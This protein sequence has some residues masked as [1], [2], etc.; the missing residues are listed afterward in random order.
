MA[1]QHIRICLFFIELTAAVGISSLTLVLLNVMQC[2]SWSVKLSST[3]VLLWIVKAVANF[4]FSESQD[5]VRKGTDDAANYKHHDVLKN[6][7]S[8][9]QQRDIPLG[10]HDGPKVPYKQ[11]AMMEETK[12]FLDEESE[13]QDHAT[14]SFPFFS[15]LVTVFFQLAIRLIVIF[16]NITLTFQRRRRQAAVG[17]GSKSVFNIPF[18]IGRRLSPSGC[19]FYIFSFLNNFLGEE[20]FD[21]DDDDDLAFKALSFDNISTNSSSILIRPLRK[22]SAIKCNRLG[23]YFGDIELSLTLLLKR[24]RKERDVATIPFI[25]SITIRM[26]VDSFSVGLFPRIFDWVECS[27]VKIDGYAFIESKNKVEMNSVAVCLRLSQLNFYQVASSL[28]KILSWGKLDIACEENNRQTTV[29]I[30]TLP[31]GFSAVSSPIGTPLNRTDGPA[32]PKSA[33]VFLGNNHENNRIAAGIHVEEMS[34]LVQT[35]KFHLRTILSCADKYSLGSQQVAVSDA[36]ND[37]TP[38]LMELCVRS[39]AHLYTVLSS[40]HNGY[41]VLSLR[42]GCL[43]VGLGGEGIL[44]DRYCKSDNLLRC[45][46]RTVTLRNEA[47]D[48]RSSGLDILKTKSIVSSLKHYCDMSRSQSRRT[49]IVNV[50][51][52]VVRVDANNIA[53]LSSYMK[54]VNEVKYGIVDLQDECRQ[55][56]FKGML[57]SKVK[58]AKQKRSDLDR[59]EVSINNVDAVVELSAGIVREGQVVSNDDRIRFT[60]LARKAIVNIMRSTSR[61]S[62]SSECYSKGTRPR[63]LFGSRL[64]RYGASFLIDIVASCF[65]ASVTFSPHTSLPVFDANNCQQSQEVSYYVQT[66]KIGLETI[67]PTKTVGATISLTKSMLITFNEVSISELTQFGNNVMSIFATSVHGLHFNLN[68]SRWSLMNSYNEVYSFHITKILQGTGEFCLTES[69]ILVENDA[70]KE[71]II[72]V[73]LQR[74]PRDVELTWSP[75]F[76]WTQMSFNKRL[77]AALSQLRNVMVNG[78]NRSSISSPSCHNTHVY[79]N[80]ESDVTANMNIFLGAKTTSLLKICGGC[81]VNVSISKYPT[82]PIQ[83]KPNISLQARHIEVYLNGIQSPVLISDCFVFQNTIRRAFEE[84]IEEYVCKKEVHPGNWCISDEIVTD[85]DGHPLKETFYLNIGSCATVQLPPTLF[86]GDVIDDFNLLPKS[87]DIGMNSLK[88]DGGIVRR[89]RKY[90]LLTIECTIPSL[91]ISLLDVDVDA[92]SFRLREEVSLFIE[93]GKL[94]IERNSP[95]EL[96]QQLLNNIDEDRTARYNFG[97]IVQGGQLK[98]SICQLM[99]NVHPLNISVPMVRIGN[100]SI[101]GCLFLAGL[102]PTTPGIKE[103]S[104]I[105]SK[106]LCHHQ[107]NCCCPYGIPTYNSG[108]PVK[109]YTDSRIHCDELDVNYGPVLNPSMPRLNVCFKRLLPS[110]KDNGA[111]EP[112]TWWDNIRFT[113]HGPIVLFVDRLSFRWLLDSHIFI[114][115]AIFLTCEDCEL[116]YKKDISLDAINIDVSMPGVP[117]DTSVH[118]SERDVKANDSCLPHEMESMVGK[119]RHPL[120]FVP[121]LSTRM[122]F[123]WKVMH[124]GRLSCQ[125]HSIY[126]DCKDEDTDKFSLFRSDG[127]DV[128]LSFD[129]PGASGGGVVCNWVALRID[130]LPWFTHINSTVDY[131]LESDDDRQDPLP[132]FL[133]LAMNVNIGQLKIAAWYEEEDGADDDDF[134]GLCL[135]VR[136]VQYNA[137]IG[138][139]KEIIVGGP[140]KA[141]RLNVSGFVQADKDDESEFRS[142]MAAIEVIARGFGSDLK[143]EL[144]IDD[145]PQSMFEG[146]DTFGGMSTP[147]SRLEQLSSDIDELDYIVTSG[148]I[149]VFNKSLAKIIGSDRESA[150]IVDEQIYVDLDRTTWSILVS[151]LRI[152]WTLDIRDCIMAISKDLIFQIGYMKSQVRYIHALADRSATSS[153]GQHLSTTPMNLNKTFDFLAGHPIKED[154]GDGLQFLLRRE[155]SHG[156]Y[157]DVSGTQGQGSCEST[158]QFEDEDTLPTLDI[159]FSNPQVQLHSKSTGGSVIL[160]MECA[161]VEGKKFVKF[162][163]TGSHSGLVSPADLIRR[164]EHIYTLTNMEAYS[165]NPHVDVNIGLSW[166]EVDIPV[167]T[168]PFLSEQACQL[169]VLSG[170]SSRRQSDLMTNVERNSSG[171]TSGVD[172]YEWKYPSELRHHEP[173]AFQQQ[174]NIRPI[175]KKCTCSSRQLFHRPPIHYSNE[176]LKKSI[177]QGLVIELS[178]YVADDIDLEI[179][180][181]QFNLDAYQFKTTIDLIRN[182]LLKAPKPHR[183]SQ[184]FI[185]VDYEEETENAV[186]RISSPAVFEMESALWAARARRASGKKERAALHS[187]AMMLIADLENRMSLHGDQMIRRISYKLSKLVWSVQ[188][189]GQVDDVQIAFTGFQGDHSYMASGQLKTQI[190]LEDVRV[191]SSTPGP[192]A[193]GFPD[194]TSVLKPVLGSKRSPCQRCGSIFSHSN[195]G[196]EAC[197]Y[198]SGWFSAGKWTCCRETSSNAVGC[199]SAPHT[200]K[201][202]T[203]VVRVETLPPA[204]EGISL[205]SHLEVNIF[206]MVQHTLRVQISK[207]VS[208]LLMDYFF[209]DQDDVDDDDD[210]D[211]QSISTDLTGLTDTISVRSDMTPVRKKG[212]LI[213]G[214]GKGISGQSIKEKEEIPLRES[215]DQRAE[216]FFVKV[217]R[218]GNVNVEVSLGGFRALPQTRLSIC[219][220]EYSRAYKI[221][222]PAYLVQKYLYYLIHE[223]LK[224]GASSALRRKKMTTSVVVDA[225]E[226]QEDQ[227]DTGMERK[228]KTI[229]SPSWISRRSTAAQSRTIGVQDIIGTPLRKSAKK[230]KKRLFR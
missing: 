134:G 82:S 195:N 109:L 202:R 122:S 149:D 189:Q 123:S 133:S 221:G 219:V 22:H 118:P 100:F 209:I 223:V 30:L 185:K 74:G 80:V 147:F 172:E 2:G 98:L 73:R 19:S 117:Y 204:V 166:L 176:E 181:L 87:L 85:K 83:L 178:G 70:T 157:S 9:E 152:L 184:N 102:S 196:L 86:L 222:S 225:E 154:S 48:E 6:Y 44:D 146:K 49:M 127:F 155:S 39:N 114:D 148:Q 159:H 191:T 64:Q 153:N 71:E 38:Q 192:D 137:S 135:I 55:S 197:R 60:V 35:L 203:A 29:A 139:E 11:S 199:K 40:P 88:E 143:T 57:K 163:V 182:V 168:E 36:S 124:S 208:R 224:S 23:I 141:A 34:T 5:N 200:G 62:E 112:L 8:R 180:L 63:E 177:L 78:E 75:I 14:I 216:I 217:L 119:G 3:F 193:I 183:R 227:E 93:N 45:C 81:E 164:T 89:K 61:T 125:H 170:I 121:S 12:Q 18:T 52:M 130:V 101:T 228:S 173:L 140:V 220:R 207:S 206:P 28:G 175:L 92:E 95:P 215:Y 169:K 138:G 115:Q 230:K 10:E 113:I 20:G 47:I 218:V 194:P 42:L 59:I 32:V 79:V 136:Q 161:R 171:S 24:R 15:I 104:R 99:F 210:D 107:G 145:D 50:D 67:I 131:S 201:E 54:L 65:E 37:K 151:R 214:K 213:G 126:L 26:T 106:L 103:G 76:Q 116:C 211:V 187:P 186:N 90:Q 96:T 105:T 51:G 142:E 111:Q 58:I 72:T 1:S 188:S 205:Y 226:N 4:F 16:Q 128:D 167:P 68:E 69:M 129:L 198:H 144:C 174:N 66:S 110:P 25:R 21:D 31:S 41:E 13:G 156:L 229:T 97:P 212:I 108:I 53:K 120:L 165:L 17:N 162:L 27:G 179:D 46:I 77:Q 43:S 94:L 190:S 91:S 56:E 7:E 150:S 132:K 160:A 158:Q 33:V 84:E